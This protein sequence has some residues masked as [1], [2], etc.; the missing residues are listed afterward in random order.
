MFCIVIIYGQL[1][2]IRNSKLGFSDKNVVVLRNF[3]LT[4]S[5]NDRLK[6]ELLINPSVTHVGGS[7]VLPGQ[8]VD[9][10]FIFNIEGVDNTQDAPSL[11]LM[12]CDYDFLEALEMEMGEG[13]FFSREHQTDASAAIVNE[14]VIQKSGL[15]DPIGKNI[16][17][18]GLRLHII[19]VIRNFHYK[20]LHEE[21]PMLALKLFS[22]GSD[23]FPPRRFMAIRI[24]GEQIPETLA[25]IKN[26]WDRIAQGMP[27]AYSFLDESL[28]YWYNNERRAGQVAVVFCGLAVFV[29]CLG[30]FGLASFAAERKKKEIG[31]RK[32]LGASVSRVSGLLFREYIQLIVVSIFLS[33]PPATIVMKNWLQKFAYRTGIGPWPFILSGTAALLITG[34]T[35]SYQVIKAAVTNPLPSLRN[36]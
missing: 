5:Q 36:E 31:I 32:V 14:E 11:Y 33:W 28:G 3:G 26:T 35:V 34:L 30:L 8:I 16:M 21:M 27:Y 10:K 7:S 13:R 4:N 15:S 23:E 25:F 9:D 24:K 19:G 29:S 22:G 2:Y 6:T 20:S 12:K 1:N 17:I 18:G